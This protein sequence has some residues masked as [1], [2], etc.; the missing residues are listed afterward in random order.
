MEKKVT[1]SFFTVKKWGLLVGDC[2]NFE[3]PAQCHCTNSNFTP[4]TEKVKLTCTDA[5][6]GAVTLHRCVVFYTCFSPSHFPE[7]TDRRELNHD[8]LCALLSHL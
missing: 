4:P 3:P 8:P 5:M 1:C 7:L 2:L 6:N